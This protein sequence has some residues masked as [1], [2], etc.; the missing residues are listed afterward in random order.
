[1]G[2]GETQTSLLFG[3]YGTGGSNDETPTQMEVEHA[4]AEVDDLDSKAP[5]EDS[6]TYSPYK[7]AM[8]DSRSPY[9]IDWVI[10]GTIDDV[11]VKTDVLPKGDCG[12]IGTMKGLIVLRQKFPNEY[13]SD[14][15]VQLEYSWEGLK[16]Y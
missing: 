1:M 4:H 8:P 10:A 5:S 16:R 12:F 11:I 7:T 3:E 6:S 2:D 14:A 15:F 9:S 13:C